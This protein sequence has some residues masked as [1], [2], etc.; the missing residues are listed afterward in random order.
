[1]IY[2]FAARNIQQMAAI[3]SDNPYIKFLVHLDIRITATQKVTRRYYIENKNA[4]YHMNANDPITKYG[5]W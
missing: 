5:Q 2:S 3:G 4:I 1:M